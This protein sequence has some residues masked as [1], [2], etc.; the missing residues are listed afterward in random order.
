MT[1]NHWAGDLE[2]GTVV[3]SFGA[4]GRLNDARKAQ[5]VPLSGSAEVKEEIPT[6]RFRTRWSKQETATSQ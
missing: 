5:C 3:G 4:W 2:Y 1:A 6:D